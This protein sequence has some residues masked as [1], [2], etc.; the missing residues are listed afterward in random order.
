MHLGEHIISRES[1]VVDLPMSHSAQMLTHPFDMYLLPSQA[2]IH[3][4]NGVICSGGRRLSLGFLE[5]LVMVGTLGGTLHGMKAIGNG[6][7]EEGGGERTVRQHPVNWPFSLSPSSYCVPVISL[8][9]SNLFSNITDAPS[10]LF[11][12]WDTNLLR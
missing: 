3:T 7:K 4:L 2:E 9:L 11:S 8:Q 6:E 1:S 12:I 5:D 10:S